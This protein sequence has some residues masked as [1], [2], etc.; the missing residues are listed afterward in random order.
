MIV[1]LPVPRPVVLYTLTNYNSKNRVQGLYH[2][3]VVDLFTKHHH[4]VI[5]FF[6][7]SLFL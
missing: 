3:V 2:K 4:K 5:E 7:T 6:C 1:K